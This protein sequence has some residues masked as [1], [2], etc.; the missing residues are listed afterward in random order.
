MVAPS[1]QPTEGHNSK[2]LPPEKSASTKFAVV[3]DV[4]V[5]DVPAFRCHDWAS[6]ECAISTAT[7]TALSNA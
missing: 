5:R 2:R 6:E 3:E 7:S 4:A 1:C